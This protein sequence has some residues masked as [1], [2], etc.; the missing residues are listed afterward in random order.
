MKTRMARLL[1]GLGISSALVGIVQSNLAAQVRPGPHVKKESSNPASGVVWTLGIEQVVAG[2]GDVNGDGK[3]DVIVGL[4]S[5]DP[6]IPIRG[7][8]RVQLGKGLG[9]SPSWVWLVSGEQS[10][11]NFGR[12]V[13]SAG[14]VNGD[15]HDDVLVGAPGYTALGSGE[16][17]AYLYL[18]FTDGLAHSPAWTVDGGQAGA[19]LGLS[20]AGAGDVN[21]DGY[22]DVVVGAPLHDSASS[23]V[24]RAYLFLGSASG[25]ATSPAWS[26][27]GGQ[28]GARFGSA[29]SSAG[30]VDGDGYGDVL[31]GAAGDDLGGI[32]AGRAY[33]FLGS[34]VGLMPTPAW[35]VEGGQAGEELGLAL[36]AGDVNADGYA[37]VVVAAPFHAGVGIHSGRAWLY[38]GSALG[39]AS[40][41]EWTVEGAQPGAEFGRSVAIGDLNGDGPAEII[42]G[43][44]GSDSG[45]G[46]VHVFRGS[47][48][49][50]LEA[51]SWEA[52]GD[53]PGQRLGSTV[54]SPGDVDG[55]GSGDLAVG[56]DPVRRDPQLGA[57]VFYGDEMPIPEHDWMAEGDAT[58]E[59]LGYFVAN[60]GDVDDDGHDDLIVGTDRQ[61]VLAFMGSS[62]GPEAQ[63][64]WRLDNGPQF[65]FL[66][67]HGAGAG[68]VN[69]D[70]Y[71][72]VILSATLM[73]GSYLDTVLVF[74][75]SAAGLSAAPDW[76]MLLTE[77]G[78]QGLQQRV[79]G[80]GDVNGD[81]YDDVIVGS[82]SFE[83]D[84]VDSPEG[85][86][87]VF[88][89][90]PA[91]LSTH[92]D[93]THV[94]ADA[95]YLGNSVS[96][97]G[98]V[99]KDGYDD[100]IVG[101]FIHASF[102][103][104]ALVFLG[105]ATGLSS[106]PA[107]TVVGN[108]SGSYPRFGAV[109]SSAG[110][111]NGDG[112][113]DVLVATRFYSNP[114]DEEGAAFLYLG[115]PSGPST[116]A[117]WIVEG[118]RIDAAYG[119][120]AAGAGDVNGDGY[121]DV[122]VGSTGLGGPL[123]R[124]YLYLG[125]PS[126]LSMIP[127]R[128]I[129]HAPSQGFGD[130]VAGSGDLNGDGF[131]DWIVGAPRLTNGQANDGAAFAYFGNRRLG[132]H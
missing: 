90:G 62:V 103:G 53:Q 72:D 58:G 55:D 91:G 59:H 45:V 44:P 19:G 66:G 1:A 33:L 130:S 121:D 69:G 48:L 126:G 65:G 7:Q 100:V 89:G 88:L 52:A 128:A 109:V 101:A 70:G 61:G 93:W 108:A 113:G 111:V 27:E 63:A 12:A 20:V 49:G 123:A 129:E 80:A 9:L 28:G 125:S 87:L 104:E 82:P 21:G 15:G 16:G 24:G 115:S 37:D 73:D 18:G 74:H 40:S 77:G 75:G 35:T 68:D 29:V 114:E 67:I 54:A 117:A 41:P 127:T 5:S 4:V 36:C 106:A 78:F 110:D 83:A 31:V 17:R 42:A 64:S 105:S 6:G 98:D 124:A 22:D 120:S 39:L 81:G 57:Q 3:R 132:S 56:S 86:A 34:S 102:Q 14:D 47:I 94:G 119:S 10:R 13:F 79:S 60:A 32:D 23:N 11:S 116:S 50:P 118:N 8:A 43:A 131:D 76:V 96:S 46:H 38:R 107:W 99:N 97:A 25:L 51:S 92:A 85:R 112:Y 30:D 2:A 26:A 71:G 95:D 122:V 84:G